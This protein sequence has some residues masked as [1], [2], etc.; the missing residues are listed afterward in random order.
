MSFTRPDSKYA[1]A[2]RPRERHGE[3]DKTNTW[4]VLSP[5]Y[6]LETYTAEGV[7]RNNIFVTDLHTP[8]HGVARS[9]AVANFA[10]GFPNS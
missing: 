10:L 3:D 5:R 8:S 1:S 4:T 9:V 6:Q 7:M 2:C